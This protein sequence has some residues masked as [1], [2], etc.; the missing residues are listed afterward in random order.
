MAQSCVGTVSPPAGSLCG[1]AIPAP[2]S[3]RQAIYNYRGIP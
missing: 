2:P 3:T 1:L